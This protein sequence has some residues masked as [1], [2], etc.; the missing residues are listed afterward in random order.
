VIESSLRGS[1]ERCVFKLRGPAEGD[2]GRHRV[3]PPKRVPVRAVADS[4][5]FFH[6][7]LN[8][9]ATR[10]SFSPYFAALLWRPAAKAEQGV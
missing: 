7:G 2:A 3:E 10:T 9:A 4:G 1:K 5:S 6:K 8:A